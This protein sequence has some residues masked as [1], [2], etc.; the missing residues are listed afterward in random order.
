MLVLLALLSHSRIRHD[1]HKYPTSDIR[2][3]RR[4]G[5][6]YPQRDA[7][8]LAQ[9]SQPV[10]ISADHHE[11]CKCE[12]LCGVTWDELNRQGADFS[13]YLTYILVTKQPGALFGPPEVRRLL[14]LRGTID[15]VELPLFNLSMMYLTQSE[16][17]S[18]FC[19]SP[20]VTGIMGWVLVGERFN[21]AQVAACCESLCHPVVLHRS[22]F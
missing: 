5:R 12:F 11:T 2:L 22:S 9:C 8:L 16:A 7:W 1:A 17:T 3:R 13:V 21:R 18:C 19:C 20:L 14:W 15:A 10:S 4:S 6:Q